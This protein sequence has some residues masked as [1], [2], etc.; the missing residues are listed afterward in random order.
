MDLK[1]P[2]VWICEHSLVLILQ[3]IY[4]LLHPANP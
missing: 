3:R 4:E 1:M 2:Q